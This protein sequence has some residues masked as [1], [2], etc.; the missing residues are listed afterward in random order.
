MLR[1]QPEPKPVYGKAEWETEHGA[2]DVRDIEY[3]SITCSLVPAHRRA[4]ARI[5]DLHLVNAGPFGDFMWTYMS[6]CVITD[7]VMGLFRQESLTGFRPRNASIVSVSGGRTRNTNSDL[8]VWELEVQG[9]AGN[10]RPDSGIRLLYVCP[11]CGYTVYSSFQNGII[12]DEGQWD[13]NDFLTVNGYPKHMIM[14]ER[15]KDLVIRNQLT[16]CAIFRSE[17]LRWGNLPRPEQRPE[18]FVAKR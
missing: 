16:N 14:T 2:A 18:L 5:G 13:G 3:E 6:E 7:R 4:G 17:D 15:V 11:E 10:A 12:V 9:K 1:A 8:R